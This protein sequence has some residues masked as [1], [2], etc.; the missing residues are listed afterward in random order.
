MTIHEIKRRTAQTSPYYFSRKTM[1]FFGQTLKS[2]SVRKQPDGR[3]LISAP[4]LDNGRKVG[5]SERYFN[6]INNELELN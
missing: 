4:M 2:F 5:T 6:P 1:K 3:Y